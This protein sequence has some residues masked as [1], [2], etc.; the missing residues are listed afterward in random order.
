MGSAVPQRGWTELLAFDRNAMVPPGKR[1]R[2]DTLAQSAAAP[3]QGGIQV[4]APTPC[5]ARELLDEFRIRNIGQRDHAT[6]IYTAE[7]LATRVESVLALPEISPLIS[8]GY[9]AALH[10]VRRILDGLEG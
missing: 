4:S 10:Q 1:R 8:P 7:H 6:T 2:V 3:S 5:T 9:N